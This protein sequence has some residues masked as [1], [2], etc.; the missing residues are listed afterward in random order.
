MKL[1]SIL[2]LCCVLVLY[3]FNV[4]FAQSFRIT[5]TVTS[6]ASNQPLPGATVSLKGSRAGAV[7]DS[8]G[9]FSLSVPGPGS[10]IVVSYIG[11]ADQQ[12]AVNRSGS[13][14]FQMD[15]KA[16]NMDEVVVI[17]YGSQK[18]TNVTGSISRVKASQLEDQPISRIE[19]A[20]QGRTSGLTIAAS[21]GQPG[22]SSTVRVRGTTS[23]NSSDPLYVVDGVIVDNGG[24]D[25][26]NS[27]DIESIEVLK[28]AAS[29]AIYGT[30][31]A[32]GVILVTTKKGRAGSMQVAY[33]GY[34]GSQAPAH[35]LD[36]LNAEQYATLRNEASVAGGGGILFADPASLG[37]GTDWQSIIFNNN[38]RIQDHELSISGGNE[39]STYYSSFGFYDQ[40]GIV[41]S[42]ISEYKRFNAR[43]NTAHK[44]KPW[45]NF[46]NNF[47]YSYIKNQGIGN[48]NSEFGG[49]LSSAINLDP[50]TPAVVTDP[51]VAGAPPYSN[52]TVF[53]DASGNP[54]G[55]STLVANEMVNPLAYIQGHLGNYGWSHN[56]VGNVYA[57]VE[58]VKNLKIRSTIGAKMSFW[59]GETFNPAVYYNAS[60]S[61]SRNS[62]YRESNQGLGWTWEN[63]ASYQ[64]KFGFHDLTLLVGT[65]AYVD[66]I[67]RGV[68]AN[69]YNLPVTTFKEATLNYSIP[70]ADRI[71]GGYDG[72][73]HKIS[74]VYGRLIYSYHDRYLFTGILRRDGSSRF[75]SNNKYGYF[76]SASLGWVATNEEFFPKN[77]IVTF[78][79]VRGSYGVNGSDALGDFAYV[80]TVSGG[81]NYTF[82]NDNYVIGYSP[83]APANPDLKWEQ[84]SQTDIGFDATLVKNV[85]LSF[86]WYNKKTTG[87]LQP[88]IIPGY[89]GTSNP[90]GNVASMMNKG[91]EVEVGYSKQ[92]GNVHLT[93]NGNASYL[94]NEITDLGNGVLYR[95]GASFQS[96]DY[97]LSRTAIGHP[98]GAFYGFVNE[99]IFQ[100]QAEVNSYVNKEGGLIQPNAKPGDFK[101]ADLNSDGKID[102]ADRTFIGD[103]TP[104]WSYGF[105]ATATYKGFDLTVFGQGAAGN[106]IFNGLRRLDLPAANWSTAALGRW[107]GEGT[108]NTFPRLTTNDANKNF[109]SPSTF[110][111]SKGDYFRIKTVQLGYTLPK[112]ILVKAGIQR[113]R[114][115]VSGA[116]LVTFTKYTGYDPEIGGSSYG[117]DRGVYPQARS[118]MVGADF[119]F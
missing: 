69:Y 111:L 58:P 79:K 20:L 41:A 82:G 60:T 67:A 101:W 43:L 53:G 112:N 49:P 33:H 37:K 114:V 108:S 10:V 59:G 22:A 88:I 63:T 80:S 45:L 13:Y 36:L 9:H 2:L 44:I 96:S 18:K 72:V 14:N 31:A 42:A 93:L 97:E 74:S 65:G 106:D 105:T 11:S 86:D 57:E 32:A 50:L 77:N 40:Q 117:I 61:T 51:A 98:I 76:P 92:I 52:H 34:Y 8:L 28:D 19:Q 107:T 16:N 100:N 109:S 87:M 81:R 68:N 113:V 103:P 89:A 55:I 110:Y 66:N 119:T 116:N 29:A 27:A 104:T 38:A 84:T 90:T 73:E 70:T 95:T 7:T 17:G 64:R 56:L 25:Y 4:V 30:R 1:K 115:Y 48:T 12:L 99:G 47:G 54:Y 24:I 23:I 21:S 83:N 85:T 46:G 6:R 91:L 94:Q 15:E 39:K 71:A 35:K 78:L 62:Y 3:S 75:G 102:Q 118:L 5:G 26:L